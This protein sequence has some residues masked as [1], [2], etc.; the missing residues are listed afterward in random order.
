MSESEF[1][2]RYEADRPILEAWGRLVADCVTR[3]LRERLENTAPISEFLRIP[4]VPRMKDNASII[5]KAFYRQKGYDDPY[6]EITDKVGVRF[7]VL[8]VDQVAM[9]SDVIRSAPF[10]DAREDR[11]YILEREANPL[12]FDYQAVHF[13]L[14]SNGEQSFDGVTIPPDTPCEVQI[15][16]LLQHAHSE[17]SHETTFKPTVRVPNNVRR[18]IARCMALIETTDYSFQEAV[19]TVEKR[20]QVMRAFSD[21]LGEQLATFGTLEYDRKVNGELYEHL[22]AI[23]PDAT[24]EKIIEWTG[25]HPSLRRILAE[26]QP[27]SLLHRQPLILLVYW[28]AAHHV[29]ALATEWPF[30]TELLA[31]IRRD[32]G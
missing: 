1:I 16:T 19:N 30:S 15:R 10:W 17:L 5:A 3:S 26:R 21:P 2:A 29:E 23:A 27:A 25:S 32:L 4:P 7:V 18:L 20:S 12:E 31:Q 9:V 14:F 13:V 28:L 6:M 11:H 8:L 22:H 24:P